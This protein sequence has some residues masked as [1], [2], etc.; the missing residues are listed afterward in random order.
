[1]SLT[2]TK[3]GALALIEDRGRPG[4][5][6]LGISDSGAADMNSHDLANRLVGNHPASATIEALLGNFAAR[7]DRPCTV[8]V[9]GA[10]VPVQVNGEPA[11]FREPIFLKK[12]DE[13]SL[14][15]PIS[16]LRAYVAFRGGLAVEPVLDS[17]SSDPTTG[18]GPKALKVG[19]V[20]PLSDGRRDD[21][22]DV[23]VPCGVQ[24][25]GELLLTGIWGPR[26]DWFTTDARRAFTGQ[27][28]A[29]TAE[30]DR[31]G[32]RLSGEALTR[33]IE[34]ELPSEGVVRGAVQVPTN[35][36]PVVF[37]ADH[38]TTGGYPVIAVLD[39]ESV[40]MLAQAQPGTPVRFECRSIK[41]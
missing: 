2:V 5:A 22:P 21:I 12:G 11:A 19:D 23:S 18:L 15:T 40:N 6:N 37:L 24:T 20:V 41:L 34:G 17:R 3:V 31:V 26:D 33:S 32:V 38:P 7:V 25:T 9:T 35:G 29:V 1:M 4:Y 36:Q 28:W 13:I 16:G 8:A 39:D 27:T 10:E 30:G 14:G